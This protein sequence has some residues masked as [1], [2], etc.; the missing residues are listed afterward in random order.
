LRLNPDGSAPADNPFFA[1]GAAVGGEVGGNIQKVFAYGIRNSFGMDFDPVSGELWMAE[2]A[3]DAFDELNRVEPGMNGGWV[4]I[5]GPGARITQYK[6]IE[7]NEFGGSLQQ[8]RWPPTEIADSSADAVSRLFMLPGAAYSDPE[9][10]W[11]YAVAPA[12]LGFQ[13]GDALGAEYDGVMFVGAARTFLDDGYLFRFRLDGTRD[14]VDVTADP[15]LSDRVADNLVK[16]G[17]T[18]SEVLR[19]GTGFGAATDIQTGPNGNLFVVSLT[20][21]QVYEISRVPEPAA[22]A[23]FGCLISAA[24]CLRPRRSANNKRA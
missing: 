12:S 18:E 17:V 22:L 7:V 5:M 4:Q 16:F 15:R 11:K 1:A 19:F 24:I 14:N 3:D 9:F 20:N 6:D 10:S 8:D 13:E 2:N 23:L 21:G